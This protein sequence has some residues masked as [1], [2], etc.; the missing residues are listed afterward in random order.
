MSNVLRQL[1]LFSKA[2][3]IINYDKEL[4]AS[5]DMTS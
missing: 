3:I 1:L 4:L 5:C 2:G